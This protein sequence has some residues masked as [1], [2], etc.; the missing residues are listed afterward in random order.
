MGLVQPQDRDV[1][2]IRKHVEREAIDAPRRAG[3]YSAWA[4]DAYSLKKG[5]GGADRR[6]VLPCK[7][8]NGPPTKR[9][10]LRPNRHLREAACWVLEARGDA[11][12]LPLVQF[13]YAREGEGS[14]RLQP[15]CQRRPPVLPS[16]DAIL[17]H[18][19]GS[20]GG[21]DSFVCSVGCSRVVADESC[22]VSSDPAGC[23]GPPGPVTNGQTLRAIPETREPV[24][25]AAPATPVPL[26]PPSPPTPPHRAQLKHVDLCTKVS[27]LQRRQLVAS[28]LSPRVLKVPELEDDTDL[29]DALAIAVQNS[30]HNSASFSSS[31]CSKGHSSRRSSATT[32]TIDYCGDSDS[33]S[34]SSSS[35]SSVESPR[36]F[37]F[38]GLSAAT[39]P[40]EGSVRFN[41]GSE[42]RFFEIG[43]K[44][45]ETENSDEYARDIETKSFDGPSDLKLERSSL[46]RDRKAKALDVDWFDLCD[47]IADLMSKPRLMLGREARH[48]VKMQKSNLA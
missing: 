46:W 5:P 35:I 39:T 23:R 8:V 6:M 4:D 30:K 48:L 20:D 2:I 32:I 21:M 19:L 43:D 34:P 38:S 22:A 13:S 17:P 41:E 18:L 25:P 16:V 29:S 40:S 14:A 24:S 15:D 3:S 1:K 44:V 47:T 36:E 10:A 27:P 7:P 31:P 45:S 28:G 42:V 12:D 37:A 33:M 9:R 11:F 26:A